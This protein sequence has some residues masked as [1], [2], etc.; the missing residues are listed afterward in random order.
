[1]IGLAEIKHGVWV[2]LILFVGVELYIKGIMGKATSNAVR[3]VAFLL[4]EEREAA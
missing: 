3:R 2:G 1:M 4:V